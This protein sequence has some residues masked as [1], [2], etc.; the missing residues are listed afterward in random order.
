MAVAEFPVAV[1]LLLI[2]AQTGESVTS[3]L[4][5]IIDNLPEFGDIGDPYLFH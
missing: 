5:I 4:S 1:F 2:S 3:S